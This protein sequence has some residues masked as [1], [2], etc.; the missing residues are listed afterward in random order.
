M[1]FDFFLSSNVSPPL[2]HDTG[3]AGNT[4]SWMLVQALE[5]VWSRGVLTGH[6]SAAS[7]PTGPVMAEPFISPLGL[8]ICT[9]LLATGSCSSNDTRP[10][11]KDGQWTCPK[12]YHTGVVLEVQE[13]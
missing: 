11:S 2:H 7:L 6:S 13:D 10:R 12:T 5:R 9:V 4:L 1:P 3:V 8:T